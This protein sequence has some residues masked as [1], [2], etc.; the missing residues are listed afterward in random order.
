MNKKIK[1]CLELDRETNAAFRRPQPRKIWQ[2]AEANRRI[3]K[4]ETARPG[5]Y[6]TATAPF[7]REPQE[8]FTAAEV[9]TTALYWA[10]RLGKTT[11][12]ENLHGATMDE[13]P[14]NILHVMPTLET[15]A[16]WSKQ[17][18]KP[19]I[20]GCE[21]LKKKISPSRSRDSGNTIR[22]KAY[23]GGTI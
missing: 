4:S 20:D 1:S 22:S 5:R 13:N 10:K 9:Q 15:I 11:M 12:I 3:A 18:L 7:Q 23:P 19:L 16:K 17:F 2:W 14:R 6:R 21:S 8:S